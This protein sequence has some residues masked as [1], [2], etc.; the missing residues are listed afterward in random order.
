MSSVLSNSTKPAP[1]KEWQMPTVE[2]GQLVLWTWNRSAERPSVGIVT[3]VGR[4]TVNLSLHTE[5]TKDHVFKTGVR[6]ENDPFL[7]R[8]PEHDGGVWKLTPRDIAINAM[9]EEFEKRNTK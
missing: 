9:L 6:N 4:E 5:N 2:V 1:P 3:A 8:S 7:Q